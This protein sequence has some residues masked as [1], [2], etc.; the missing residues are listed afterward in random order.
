MAWSLR[1]ALT[2]AWLSL[3]KDK[4]QRMVVHRFGFLHERPPLPPE[5]SPRLPRA[6]SW[7]CLLVLHACVPRVSHKTR[8][9]AA[10]VVLFAELSNAKLHRLSYMVV[11]FSALFVMPCLQIM[12]LHE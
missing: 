3:R 1:Y 11:P 12:F 6:N 2:P 4:Y 5:G 7:T 9:I 8:R 10:I